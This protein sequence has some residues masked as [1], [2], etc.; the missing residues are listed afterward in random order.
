MKAL[1]EPLPETNDGWEFANPETAIPKKASLDSLS[2]KVAKGDYPYLSNVTVAVKG[3]LVMD[4]YFNGSNRYR[5][6]DT[7]S[8]GKSIASL[9]LGIAIDQGL[10]ANEHAPVFEHFGPE[11][12]KDPAKAAVTLH[13]LLTMSPGLDA[14]D[15]RQSPGNE[16]TYQETSK[17]EEIVL[18]LEM[19]YKPGSQFVY[20]S[21]SAM[22]VG[23]VLDEVTPNGLEAYAKKQV[24]DPLGIENLL[25]VK[26]PQKG[27]PYTAGGLRLTA[28]DLAKIGQLY[29][30]GGVW[31]GKRI[32]SK[33]WI[34]RSTK[35]HIRVDEDYEY[36]YYWWRRPW[37][38]KGKDVECYFA[39]GNGGNKI[40][41][42]P[43]LEA[44]VVITSTAY[45]RRE[46]HP[47]SNR[48]MFQHILPA[49]IGE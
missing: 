33:D 5:I 43:E 21:A 32:V 40:I 12:T 2:K 13:H 11:Y 3:K 23:L 47:H 22:L 7:R 30:D 16:N 8:V 24:F 14:F 48:I 34:E 39:S 45:N 49:L 28:R 37:H 6:H 46:G 38:F 44:V 42:L 31:Q 29:L 35:T 25:W 18:N 27:K 26:T 1:G 10:V 17:W 20:N 9:L 36:G 4:A 15:D 19:A 41:V